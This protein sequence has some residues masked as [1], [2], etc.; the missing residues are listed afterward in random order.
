MRF[1]VLRALGVR[2]VDRI[3]DQA[4][5]QSTLA[6]DLAPLQFGFTLT[7]IFVDLGSSAVRRSCTVKSTGE[8]LRDPHVGR[9]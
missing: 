9:V 7:C 5:V 6:I 3:G 4:T 1:R 2:S 8:I